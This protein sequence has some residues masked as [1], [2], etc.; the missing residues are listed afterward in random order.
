MEILLLNFSCRH[1][2]LVFSF[3]VYTVVNFVAGGLAGCAATLVAHPVDVIRTR[4][5][6]QLGDQVC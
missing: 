2:S 1:F 5:V 3:F 6:A 4:F